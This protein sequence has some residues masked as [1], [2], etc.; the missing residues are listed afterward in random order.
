MHTLN[1]G[2]RSLFGLALA[3]A[4]TAAAHSATAAVPR[5]ASG[6]LMV[7]YVGA[8]DCAP[9]RTFEAEDMPR[10]QASGLSSTVRFIR[11][12]APKTSQ[13]FN[14][15][16]WPNEAK[17]YLGAFTAPIVPSFMLVANGSVV[18]TGG[19]LR[20]WRQLTLPKLEQLAR[21]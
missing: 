17:P 3:T 14:P 16:Y 1:L 15:R 2:R 9:C 6:D 13:A 7:I 18:A 19:G 5:A 21:A 12:V 10:W 4:A 11:V 20:N 8:H